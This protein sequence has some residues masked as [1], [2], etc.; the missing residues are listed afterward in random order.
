MRGAAICGIEKLTNRALTS[1]S[2]CNRSYGLSSNV[3]FSNIAHDIRDRV[4]DPISHAII[5]KNQLT[6]LIKKGDLILSD[7]VKEATTTF[8]QNM[9][10][11]SLMTGT[12]PIYA[13]DGDE[14]PDRL[15]NSHDGSLISF[16]QILA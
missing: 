7:V 9:T 10:E 2:P 5:A 15:Y 11:G 4:I 6:W 3:P 14:F 16:L 8:T 12:I 1:M 13:Y